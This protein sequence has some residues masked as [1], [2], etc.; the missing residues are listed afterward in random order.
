[1]FTKLSLAA[2]IAAAVALSAPVLA[3]QKT[4]MR[5]S[6]LR[7]RMSLP[8]GDAQVPGSTLISGASKTDLKCLQRSQILSIPSIPG[9]PAGILREVVSN[10]DAL[11]D[12][13]RPWVFLRR[14]SFV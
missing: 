13:G 1:M 7:S 9:P 11:D 5:Q 10:Y 6:R 12:D 3:T 8:S 14:R 2:L 4:R